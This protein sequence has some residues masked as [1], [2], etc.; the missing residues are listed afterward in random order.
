LRLQSVEH[1]ETRTIKKI[2]ITGAEGFLG[3]NLAAHLSQRDGVFVVPDP[4]RSYSLSL[5]AE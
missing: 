4:I 2:L 1:E 3:H 5:G